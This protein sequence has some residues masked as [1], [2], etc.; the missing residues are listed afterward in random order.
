MD[1]STIRE[2][3]PISFPSAGTSSP[4]SSF[5]ISF[6]TT[7]CFLMLNI[8]TVPSEE[9]LRNTLTGRASLTLLRISNSRSAFN[10]NINPTPVASS[11]AT[12]TPDG[13]IKIDHPL[14]STTSS[15]AEI[16]I[17]SPNTISRTIIIGSL[18]FS[19]YNFHSGSFSGGGILF[20]PT[21]FLTSSES[22][23]RQLFTQVFFPDIKLIAIS[24]E[25][26]SKN[27]E[28]RFQTHRSGT[29]IHKLIIR[30]RTAA[31]TQPSASYT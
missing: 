13:S 18:N 3:A 30:R 21:P 9:F 23:D 4:L 20:F 11:R 10:S 29:D 15:Y 14:S 2:V 25:R 27:H 12:R 1:S 16:P 22:L 17:E 26:P 6:S 7:S 31:V 5:T 8:L 24:P 19:R 28:N